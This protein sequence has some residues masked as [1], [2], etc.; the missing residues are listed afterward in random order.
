MLLCTVTSEESN[1]DITQERTQIIHDFVGKLRIKLWE[2]HRVKL[3]STFKSWD[4]LAFCFAIATA[5]ENPPIASTNPRAA[6]S[7]PVQTL[8]CA[9]SSISSTWT[10]LM[11]LQRDDF[12]TKCIF[13]C[14][15]NWI[16]YSHGSWKGSLVSK[17]LICILRWLS[18]EFSLIWSAS[19]IIINKG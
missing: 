6:A 2:Q 11:E 9:T 8:P 10:R 4:I 17:L 18:K 12:L 13:K 3:K 5:R 14:K 19:T 7:F 16:L 15:F 1:L